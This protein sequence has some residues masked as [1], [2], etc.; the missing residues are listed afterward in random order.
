MIEEGGVYQIDTEYPDGLLL[1]LG[2]M[3]QGFDMKDDPIMCFAWFTLELDT[4]PSVSLEAF[5]E[6][7]GGYRVGKGKELGAVL[8]F[9]IEPFDDEGIFMV[10]H[11]IHPGSADVSIVLLRSIDG[12]TELLIVGA[13][14]L[15]DGPGGTTHAEEMSDTLLSC[16]DLGKGAIDLLIQIYPEG[17]LLA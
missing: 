2:L 10:E 11:L 1:E 9:G 3:L 4:D 13:H 8:A 6:I 16:T 17:F 5:L 15:S 14:R 7:D 12:I